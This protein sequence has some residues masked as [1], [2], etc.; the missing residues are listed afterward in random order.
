MVMQLQFIFLLFRRSG[1]SLKVV[2][3]LTLF[4]GRVSQFESCCS[5]SEVRGEGWLCSLAKRK[6]K[7]GGPEQKGLV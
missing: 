6:R 4:P 2:V 7:I 5:C 1:D 3:L